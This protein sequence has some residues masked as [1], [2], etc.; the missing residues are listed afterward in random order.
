MGKLFFVLPSAKVSDAEGDFNHNKSKSFLV[1]CSP[2]V[3]SLIGYVTMLNV[4]QCC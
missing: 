4:T 3:L 2:Q 1:D